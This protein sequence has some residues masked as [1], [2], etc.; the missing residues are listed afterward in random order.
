[1]GIPVIRFVVAAVVCDDLV[2][3]PELASGASNH[4]AMATTTA[5]ATTAVL[6]RGLLML[7]PLSIGPA[8]DRATA[9]VTAHTPCVPKQP[10][11]PHSSATICLVCM[12]PASLAARQA[13]GANAPQREAFEDAQAFCCSVA[14]ACSEG[15]R[16]G[17]QEAVDNGRRGPRVGDRV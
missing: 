13:A 12:C 4:P 1:T 3:A 16:V 15:E 7:T 2:T 8:H 6:A 17:R 5:A 9:C 10:L 11:S 14:V